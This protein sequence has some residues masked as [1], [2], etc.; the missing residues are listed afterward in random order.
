MKDKIKIEKE[1]YYYLR[2][3]GGA[4]RVT[5]CLVASNGNMARGVSF[6]SHSDQACKSTG[7]KLALER[8]RKSLY[9]KRNWLPI[10]P[11][12]VFRKAGVVFQEIPFPPHK[13]SFGPVLSPLEKKIMEK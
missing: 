1:K 8:A 4:P 2:D 3:D 13:C 10:N 6:C 11:M 5:V 12:Y 9:S 7:R